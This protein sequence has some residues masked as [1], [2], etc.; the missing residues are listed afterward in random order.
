MNTLIWIEQILHAAVFHIAGISKCLAFGTLV[1]KLEQLR[2][3]APFKMTPNQGRLVGLLEIVGAIG[4]VLPPAWT[5]D[6]LAPDYLLVRLAAMCL[7][8]LMV[9]STIDRF[10]RGE[11]AAPV[12]SAFLLAFF[13]IV[14]REPG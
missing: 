8:F 7:A 12:I 11:S 4:V 5:P 14:G 13:V 10:R 2:K 9:V 3:A 1:K 6:A